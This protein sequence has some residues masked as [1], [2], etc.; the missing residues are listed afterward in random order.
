MTRWHREF[1]LLLAGMATAVVS[2]QPGRTVPFSTVTG[3]PQA[4]TA[5]IREIT[6]TWQ[7]RTAP[8]QP[9]VTDVF[10]VVSQRKSQGPL[11]RERFPQLSS[12]QLVVLVF[13]ANDRLLDWRLVRN[14][15]IARTE[16]P[17]PNGVLSGQVVQLP[18]ARL[19]VAVADV[20]GARTLR[21]G[22]PRWNGSEY[23]ID[24]VGNDLTIQ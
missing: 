21:I 6:L 22:Q 5:T 15:R 7:V 4:I 8:N 9:N 20:A 18:A 10:A 14:P 16:A 12:D 11:R 13:D 24:V 3:S 2:A 23:L 17:Q 19:S 1:V